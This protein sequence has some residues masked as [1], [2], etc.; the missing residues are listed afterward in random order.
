MFHFS[1]IQAE[2]VAI[3]TNRYYIQ[4]PS[5]TRTKGNHRE[6]ARI[7]DVAVSRANGYLESN[8]L[9]NVLS[10]VPWQVTPAGASPLKVVSVDITFIKVFG[11]PIWELCQGEGKL[12]LRGHT[13]IFLQGAI[14]CSTMH[15]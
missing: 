3:F 1:R 2:L 11:M 4:L 12:V 5:Q 8:M 10:N 15:Y 6:D 13:S 9:S 7:C 14:A